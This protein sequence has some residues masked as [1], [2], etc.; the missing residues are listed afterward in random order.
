MLTHRYLLPPPGRIVKYCNEHV[1]LS[2]CVS[3]GISQKPHVQ[4]SQNFPYML[5]VATW[6]GPLMTVQYVMYFR[7]CGWRH[8][9]TQWV[10]YMARV[11]GNV[12]V[13]AVLQRVVEISSTFAR[14]RHAVALCRCVQWQQIAHRGRSLI[15]TTALFKC[16]QIIRWRNDAT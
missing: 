9:F 2:L 16:L 14:R 13:G 4:T 15:S 11:V 7:F 5:T 3:A 6:L 8:V 12:D 1:C 10:L